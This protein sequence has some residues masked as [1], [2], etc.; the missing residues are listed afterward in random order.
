MT[1]KEFYKI[2]IKPYLKDKD[3][4]YNRQLFSDVKDMLHRDKQITDKQVNNWDYP[5]NKFFE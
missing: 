4:P 5:K 2:H 3:K 1:Q